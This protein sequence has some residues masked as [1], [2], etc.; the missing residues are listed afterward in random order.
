MG[1]LGAIALTAEQLEAKLAYIDDHIEGRP[2]GVD[3][4]MPAGYVSAGGG[5]GTG[6]GSVDDL[7]KMLPIEHR[8]F[9]DA[10]LAEHGVPPLPEGAT[11]H[12]ALKGWTSSVSRSQVNIALKH[13]IALLANALGPPPPDVVEQAHAQGVKVAALVGSVEHAKR[14]VAVGV[15][16]IVAQG[17]EAGGHCGEISTFVLVPA[18]VDAVGDVPVLAAGGVGTGGH[19]AAAIALGAQGVWTGSIWLTTAEA[20]ASAP[21]QEKL[22]AA[23]YRDTIR[24][25]AISGKPARQ[26]RTAWSEAW[27]NTDN[28]SPLPMPLQFMLTAEAV[29][30]IHRHA[31]ATGDGI[32]LLTAPVGQTVGRM[33]TIRPAAEVIADLVR[34]LGEA[35]KRIADLG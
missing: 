2:Y 30:R 25:K 23:G 35:R 4:V 11:T 18:V 5:S 1:V 32:P 6:M 28:P 27:E 7:H 21:V 33:N 13:P 26:L 8:H 20:E 29:A 9:V 14:Q 10:L 17:T 34:E 24:S 19:I 31:E 16:I 12:E 22:L 15:D 3:V